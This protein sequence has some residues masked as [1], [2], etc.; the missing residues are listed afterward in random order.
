MY[1][2]S[3]RS[4]VNATLDII[5]SRLFTICFDHQSTLSV[6]KMICGFRSKGICPTKPKEEEEIPAHPSLDR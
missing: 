5:H 3:E 6:L 1:F 2:H 4:H